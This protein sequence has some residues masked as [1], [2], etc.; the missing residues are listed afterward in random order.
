MMN[1]VSDLQK[2]EFGI[3]SFVDFSQ[4]SHGSFRWI[5]GAGDDTRECSER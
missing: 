1:R 5:G 4:C 3:F 2:V